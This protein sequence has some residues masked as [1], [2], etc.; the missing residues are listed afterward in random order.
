MHKHRDVPANF[1]TFHDVDETL[2]FLKSE[3]HMWIIKNDV[4]DAHE[5]RVCFCPTLKDVDLISPTD[6]VRKKSA[7]FIGCGSKQSPR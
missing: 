2:H 7:S 4:S 1:H 3:G 6:L 5:E